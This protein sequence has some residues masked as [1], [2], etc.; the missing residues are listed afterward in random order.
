MEIYKKINYILTRRQKGRA[1]V[2]LF[3][4]VVGAILELAGVAGIMPVIN[5]ASTPDSIENTSY[6][7]ALYEFLGMDSRENFMVFL[8][9][10]LIVIYLFKNLYLLFMRH[11]Q[12]VFVYNNQYRLSCELTE[13]YVRQPYIYHANRN[14]SEVI[15]SISGDS[16]MF[17]QALSAVLQIVTEGVVCLALIVGLMVT[18][19]ALTIA[20]A[21]IFVVFMLTFVKMTR[22]QIAIFGEKAR[23][24]NAKMTMKLYQ[25]F[26]GIKDIKVLER[27][28]YFEGSYF[29]EY[30]GNTRYLKRYKFVVMLPG[31]V[32]ESVLVGGLLGVLIVKI[33]N[34][35]NIQGLVPTLA[36]F[37]VAAFR[38]LP[39]INRM[40]Q[41]INQLTYNK[42]AVDKIYPAIKE[43]RENGAPKCNVAQENGE[44]SLRFEQEVKVENITFSYPER[45]EKV[46]D[47]VSLT[48]PKNKSVAFVGPSGAGKTTLTDVILG[49]LDP[50]EGKILCDNTDIKG[51]MSAWHA[52]IGY[53]PQEVFLLDDTIRH[54][55]AFGIPES[56]IDD[57]RVKEVLKEAQLFDFV[58]SLSAGVNTSIGECGSRL[59][60]GQKQ[61]IGI[62]RALYANPEILVMDEATSALDNDTES[63][64][65]EAVN[66]L[67][68][69]KTLII[70]A[71]RLST[72]EK[73]DTVY[74]IKNGKASLLR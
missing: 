49:V 59:S 15:Q 20:T 28:D 29:R 3:L 67:A 62:A 70:I 7:K 71:H 13:Y 8:C 60:G 17:F 32:M 26:G 68:G 36:A 65:M 33:V 10:S 46:L 25:L 31:P 41:G 42:V 56:E 4:I 12:N 66:Q 14:R 19:T 5:V 74:E 61:R 45:E 16:S 47:K 39:S 34:G 51:C 22:K 50:L 38:I 54:N 23:G 30:D 24:Y 37:A 63:A 43:A 58:E 52:K 73:C 9:A 2:L 53:I 35:V 27:E 21:V 6:L 55:I 44:G 1:V 69:K 18:D 57:I 40:T 72:I 11:M 48:I 64:V